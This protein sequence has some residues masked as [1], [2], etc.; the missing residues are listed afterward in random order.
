MARRKDLTALAALGTLG[1]MLS[2][3]GDKKDDKKGSVT[4][5]QI[6]ADR[7]ATDQKTSGDKDDMFI[8]P[9][10]GPH[11]QQYDDELP[12]ASAPSRASATAPKKPAKPS[13][14]KPASG[15]ARNLTASESQAARNALGEG[16]YRPDTKYSPD[17]RGVTSETRAPRFTPNEPPVQTHF[18]PRD[19]ENAPRGSVDVTK[20]SLAERRNM[21]SSPRAPTDYRPVNE[22]FRKGGAVKGYASGGT[23][24]S[25]SKRADGIATKGK[26]RGKIC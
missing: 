16:S 13:S 21:P 26:T 15:A 12:G 10:S 11:G 17:R 24:S 14:A 2:K 23:V 8:E 9:G 1:Y 7:D 18:G 19:E 22:R 5:S 20:L 4:E 3:K 25:A 6:R